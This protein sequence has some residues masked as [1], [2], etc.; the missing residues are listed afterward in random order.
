MAQVAIT[1]TKLKFNEASALPAATA[2]TSATD[3]CTVDYTGKEDGKILLILESTAEATV[4]AKILAGNGLQ[5]TEDLEITLASG[6]KKCIVVESGKFVNVYGDNKG[7]LIVNGG[8]AIKVAA[9]EL[10]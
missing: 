3:G 5:G 9:V 4:K 1:N 7:K 10:P 8:T 2:M 6:D